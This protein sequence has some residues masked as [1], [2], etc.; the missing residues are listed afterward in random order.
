MSSQRFSRLDVCS[1][2]T[3][4]SMPML[5]PVATFD[6]SG[7]VRQFIHNVHPAG[8]L[9]AVCECC[10]VKLAIVKPGITFESVHRSPIS[11]GD[12]N[13]LGFDHAVTFRHERREAVAGIVKCAGDGARGDADSVPAEAVIALSGHQ[14]SVNDEFDC[15]HFLTFLFFVKLFL[16]L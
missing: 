8:N 10:R 12:F 5:L 9:R 13:Y 15:I 11:D 7:V 16:I 2:R 4:L 6:D 3:V 14:C 1:I